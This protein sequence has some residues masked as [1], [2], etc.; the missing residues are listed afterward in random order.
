MDRYREECAKDTDQDGKE[1]DQEEAECGA[2]VAGSLGVDDREGE[3]SVAADDGSQ[4]V[5][6][7]KDGD[8]IEKRC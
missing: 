5:D 8:G 1:N 3:R 6:A 2:L 7:V 4:I